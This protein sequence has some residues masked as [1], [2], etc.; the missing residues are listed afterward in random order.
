[1]TYRHL[2][3]EH[4]RPM[5]PIPTDFSPTGVLTD[6]IECIL[7]D[8]YGTLFI[9][10]SGDIYKAKRESHEKHHLEKLLKKYKIDQ[11]PQD[12]RSN[13]FDHIE[14]EHHVMRKKGI[15][16][17]EIV[18]EKIWQAV[19]GLDFRTV[20]MFAV[21]FELI[22]NPVYPMP[23]LKPMLQKCRRLNLLMGIIS[24]A[25]FFTPYLFDWFLESKLEDLGFNPDLTLFSYQ[26]GYAKPSSYL[27]Q[28]A[29]ARLKQQGIP[30]KAV[31]YIGNDML[32]DIYPAQKA[33]FKTALFAGD[34]RSL[35]LRKDHPR[36]KNLSPDL[37][38][39]HLNQLPDLLVQNR[40]H[41]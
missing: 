25:Q 26:F 39:T 18:I 8:I 6:K 27:F 3:A 4:I 21:E 16:V 33:G 12:L 5:E 34:A 15:D 9:S 2:V 23:Q 1:M 22:Q 10:G 28:L 29:G 13:F 41:T 31:V 37:V 20:R 36:C 11:S 30:T 24:N 17:P 38:I 40:R 35:R 14:T 19:L 7:F 32:N